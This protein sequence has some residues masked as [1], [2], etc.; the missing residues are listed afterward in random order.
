MGTNPSTISAITHQYTPFHGSNWNTVTTPC[1]IFLW[2][3]WH[4]PWGVPPFCLGPKGYQ[5]KVRKPYRVL[6]CLN[7]SSF[8]LMRSPWG[9]KPVLFTLSHVLFKCFLDTACYQHSNL[10]FRLW[11]I[12]ES[13]SWQRHERC[14]EKT[15]YVGN[16]VL[17][18]WVI[19]RD[20]NFISEPVVD[21]TRRLSLVFCPSPFYIFHYN[22]ILW[23]YSI[24]DVIIISSI[25]LESPSRSR[26][27]VY[28]R[29]SSLVLCQ[30]W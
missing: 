24:Y 6:L 13:G 18:C 12:L 25:L 30:W 2:Q 10:S 17:G 16:V 9:P 11:N 26:G 22:R 15:S 5:S 3:V 7:H 4:T 29:G 21:E 14:H 23:S 27:G 20:R 19:G 28:K 1:H 8:G